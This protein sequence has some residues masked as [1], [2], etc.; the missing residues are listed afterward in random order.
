VIRTDKNKA[1]DQQDLRA[2]AEKYRKTKGMVIV[3]QLK[4][5]TEKYAHTGG[6]EAMAD[7]LL[8]EAEPLP[9]EKLKKKSSKSKKAQARRSRSSPRRPT[10]S[11]C[12]SSSKRAR[13]TGKLTSKECWRSWRT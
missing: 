2:A 9:A 13:K 12:R 6:L 1:A 7:A 4:K 5:K 10:R 8:A 11:A 3:W